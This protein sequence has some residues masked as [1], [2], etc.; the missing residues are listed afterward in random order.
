MSV[1]QEDFAKKD[2]KWVCMRRLIHLGALGQAV[3][4]LAV[5]KIEQNK[6]HGIRAATDF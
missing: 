1:V 6:Y 3:S 5:E 2:L 4:F